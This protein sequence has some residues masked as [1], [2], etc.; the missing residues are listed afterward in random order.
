M[1]HLIISAESSLH[2]AFRLLDLNALGTLFVV[3]SDGRLCGV[4]TDGDIRRG[5]LRGLADTAPIKEVMNR[6]C[7][8]L[9]VA[10]DP[11]VVFQVQ[12][13]K[14]RVIPLVDTE[15]RPVDYVTSQR[16]RRIPVAEP[17]LAGNELSYV[18]DCVRS[19]WI[20]SRGDYIAKFEAAFASYLGVEDAITVSN[21][22][23]A[24]DLALAAF[25]IGPGDE[26]IVPD[27]TFAAT[28]NA[29]LHLGATPVL[30]DVDP[31][32]WNMA[33]EAVERAITKRTRALIPVHLYGQPADMDALNEIARRHGL[34][35]IE[36]AAE[37][38]GSQLDGR[39]V[40][41]LG[42]AA[43]FSFFANKLITTGE[44]GMLVI[45]DKARAAR[46]RQ[47]RSHGMQ[48]D[49]RYW[50]DQIG[51]NFRMTNLQA[52]IG[53]AQMERIDELLDRKLAVC[54][55]YRE[56][57]DGLPQLIL[58]QE[59]AGVLNSYWAFSVLIRGADAA[60]RDSVMERLLHRGIETRPLFYPLH[61]MP[62]YAGFGRKK[63]L[64]TS[65]R[66]SY[67]GITLPS[68]V[69]ITEAEVLDVCASLKA[70]LKQLEASRA[71]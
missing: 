42:D 17:N 63:A 70:A 34:V 65:R 25:D 12:T 41:S 24:L 44:G 19:G 33:P 58:P 68:S 13:A 31:G 1:N 67:S 64:A 66:L 49:R 61:E 28:I 71:A 14:F 46:A 4:A 26:V 32:S 27:L 7:V 8:W 52:A 35:V 51:Y 59:R 56:Q 37:A 38:L 57:L 45:R 30:V 3:D 23:T 10:I 48:P 9:P 54:R 62:P 36:D 22:S 18:I 2:E 20:S 55:I 11:D 47:L 53:L 60:I 50:H 69:N 16:H 43:C 6:N 40:G 29:P 21:G 15:H 39:P 5:L